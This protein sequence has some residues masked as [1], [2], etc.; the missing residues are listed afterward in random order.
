MK[1]IGG[2]T[3]IITALFVYFGINGNDNFGTWSWIAYIIIL[4]IYWF[5][6]KTILYSIG[7]GLPIA[8]FSVDS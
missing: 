6:I 8:E 4:I 5:S 1:V 7:E 3:G 2:V